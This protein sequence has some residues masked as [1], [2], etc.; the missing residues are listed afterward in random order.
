MLGQFSNVK[1]QGIASAVPKRVE[2]NSQFEPILG[3]RRT[4]KQI[5][6]TGV[7]RR[8]VSEE[9][10]QVSDLMYVAA[11]RLLNQLKWK[12]NQIKVLVCVTQSPNFMI[13]STAF[14]MQKRLHLPEDCMCFDVN[15]GCSGACSGIQIASSLLQA[16]ASG[17]KALVLA[18]ELSYP[19]CYNEGMPL[20]NLANKILFGA[21]AAAIGLEKAEDATMKFMTKSDGDR[22]NTIIRYFN[23]E[24]EIDGGAVLEFSINKVTQDLCKFKEYFNIQERDIDYYVFHQAQKLILDSICDEC[25]IQEEKEL[26]SL[27]E[28][29]NTSSASILLSICANIELFKDKKELKMLLCGFGVGL[30]WSMIY[31][32]IPTQNI[33]PIIETDV[34]YCEE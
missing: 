28:Y 4:Q 13:P 18:G 16:C 12:R 33:L 34:H 10:Q 25:E 11:D 27:N 22:Y 2:D 19:T 26:R 6:I 15:L 8:H 32:K 24:I 17:E 5:R 9:P 29:G 7:E 30:A 3:K 31:T 1:I 21:G 23:Q 20:S 14:F